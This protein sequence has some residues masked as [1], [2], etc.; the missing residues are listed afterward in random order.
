M[1]PVAMNLAGVVESPSVG[2]T[3]YRVDRD[4]RPVRAG[5]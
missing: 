2:Q 3:P 5:R 4:G 1:I